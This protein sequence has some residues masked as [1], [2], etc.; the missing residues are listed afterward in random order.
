[1]PFHFTNGKK[2]IAHIDTNLDG[3]ELNE[4]QYKS[5]HHNH[6]QDNETQHNGIHHNDPQDKNAQ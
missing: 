2:Y 1:V 4:T 6:N 3:T 5:T